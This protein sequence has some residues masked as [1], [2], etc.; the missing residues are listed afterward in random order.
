[1]IS[2][3]TIAFG[4][5][6]TSEKKKRRKLDNN[7]WP[8]EHSDCNGR[9]NWDLVQLNK[10]ILSSTCRQDT[11]EHWAGVFTLVSENK[12]T[13]LQMCRS[14]TTNWK[15]KHTA[16]DNCCHSCQGHINFSQHC[17]GSC[18][19]HRS[20]FI[21]SRV[22]CANSFDQS[23]HLI[24]LLSLKHLPKPPTR[25]QINWVRKRKRNLWLANT[26]ELHVRAGPSELPVRI[27]S[28]NPRES[29]V[30]A[31]GPLVPMGWS[32]CGSP[33]FLPRKL[34]QSQLVKILSWNWANRFSRDRNARHGRKYFQ[35]RN[36]RIQRR[37]PPHSS[38]LQH[39][40]SH[41]SICARS[42]SILRFAFNV[43]SESE[44]G[45][46]GPQNRSE[47]ATGSCSV[48]QCRCTVMKNKCCKAQ[49][50]AAAM[51]NQRSIL[52]WSRT[53]RDSTQNYEAS[54][55]YYEFL[56]FLYK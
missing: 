38:F 26:T 18:D 31:W 54:R 42:I 14:H 2:W 22:R 53:T 36:H 47:K 13:C 8:C 9:K 21:T 28:P 40:F 1:M 4:Q 32:G 39:N 11:C 17:L 52:G 20:D 33:S 46:G 41:S 3:N 45:A 5:T 23:T 48:C 56:S 29:A 19:Q 49:V 6:Q 35:R 50:E 27:I 10:W 43:F 16:R 7:T 15:E 24:Q 37:A 12:I 55:R 34:R 44:H 30:L 25:K 51:C